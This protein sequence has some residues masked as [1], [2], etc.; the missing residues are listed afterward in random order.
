MENRS[1]Y[2]SA[3]DV[4]KKKVLHYKV[5]IQATKEKKKIINAEGIPGPNS[6][7]L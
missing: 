7:T 5:G 3:D 1:R 2:F 4:W 6:R